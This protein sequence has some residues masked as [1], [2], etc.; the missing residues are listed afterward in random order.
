MAFT[1]NDFYFVWKTL[2]AGVTK[3]AVVFDLMCACYTVLVMLE[4]VL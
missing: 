4:R 2:N 3:M 1:I